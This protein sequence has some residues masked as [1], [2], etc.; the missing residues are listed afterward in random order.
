M[1]FNVDKYLKYYDSNTVNES[2]NKPLIKEEEFTDFFNF[3]EQDP[4]KNTFAYAYYLYPTKQN[5]NIV[6]ED[7]K[8]IP[9]PYFGRILKYKQIKYNFGDTYSRAIE[10]TNP[11]YVSQSERKGNYEKVQGFEGLLETG[12]SGLYMPIIPK[13]EISKYFVEEN[14]IWTEKPYEEISKYIAKPSSYSGGSGVKYKQL[15]V[16]RIYKLAAKGNT[17]NNPNFMYK[18]LNIKL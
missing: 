14:G 10:R 8:K 7:G 17:F 9:N 13:S 16:D 18:D 15:L 11:D 12:K 4:Q 5:K 3:M 1:E 6:G 2:A